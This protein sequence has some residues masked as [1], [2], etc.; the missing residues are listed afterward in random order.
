MKALILIGLQVDLFPLGAAEI[1]GSDAILPILR[2]WLPQF[3]Q[4]IAARYSH[5]ADHK[6]FVANYP[7]R[8]PGQEINLIGEKILLRNYYCMQNSFGAELVMGFDHQTITHTV[9]LGTDQKLLPH[10]AFYDENQE[11]DTGLQAYLTA[12]NI[13]ELYLAGLPFE[14]AVQ[15]TAIDVLNAGFSVKILENAILAREEDLL[16]PA[17]ELLKEKGT[18]FLKK[19]WSA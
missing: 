11:R 4:V 9:L 3:E 18:T 5:P 2:E 1:T 12:N 14:E 6:M 15:R 10:S 17:I 19:D 13:T 7:W 8:R 16:D